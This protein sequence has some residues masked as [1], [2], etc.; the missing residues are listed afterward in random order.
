MHL[1]FNPLGSSVFWAP[2]RVHNNPRTPISLSSAWIACATAAAGGCI[3]ISVIL[4]PDEL[5]SL[6]PPEWTTTVNEF[7]DQHG[8]GG[9]CDIV[10]DAEDAIAAERWRVG[11]IRGNERHLW[12]LVTRIYVQHLVRRPLVT[13][14]FGNFCNRSMPWG[15]MEAILRGEDFSTCKKFPCQTNAAHRP[16]LGHFK[17]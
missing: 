7:G 15:D 11:I 17:A 4:H 12:W 10:E 14:F 13:H 5:S 3:I 8:E 2:P 9:R 1:I 6:L 16:K